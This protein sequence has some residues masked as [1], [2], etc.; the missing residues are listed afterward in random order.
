MIKAG[1][2]LSVESGGFTAGMAAAARSVDTFSQ[3]MEKAKSEKDFHK[4]ANLDIAQSQL[5]AS[6]LLFNNDTKSLLNDPRLK[7]VMANGAS[8]IK[9]D[10][11]K[12]SLFKDLTRSIRELSGKIEEQIAADD[13]AGAMETTSQLKAKQAEFGRAV[14]D[15]TSPAGK[16]NGQAGAAGF[17]GAQQIST[18][19]NEGFR[20]WADSFDRAGIVG[21]FGSGDVFGAH[22]SERRKDD[23]LIGG[24]V[25][26]LGNMIGGAMM[27]N[28]KTML[29]GL[30]IM[31]G[32]NIFN[33]VRQKNTNEKSTQLAY[34]GLWQQR[35]AE[36][37]ELAALKGT[38]GDPRG[39]F[40]AAAGAANRFGF[41]AEEGAGLLGQAL[42]EGLGGGLAQAVTEQVF[43][44][45]R[46]TGADR[47]ALAGIATMSARFG[48]GDALGAGWAGLNASG[49]ESGQYSEFL[50]GMQRV[51]EDGISR[52]FV[53]SSEEVAK[54]LTMLAAMSGNSPLWQGEHGARRLSDMNAGLAN[55]TGLG[56]TSDIVA[57]R[58]AKYLAGEGASYLDAMEILEGGVTGD[59]LNKFMRLTREIEGGDEAAIVERLRQTFGFNY[60]QARQFNSG[61]NSGIS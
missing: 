55:A 45:Q 32:A 19:I 50:R 20:I 34:A 35:A 41:S 29:A 21:Q 9:V 43:K 26:T 49:M 7:T 15:L 17:L 46:A 10:A 36:M 11:E 24:G 14:Q 51:M 25:S 59:F 40:S 33:A 54:N 52:G 3:A 31:L 58:A 22:L 27:F 28:P 37:M 2:E 13:I 53:R 56:S 38:P 30:G 60:T 61:W 42:R 23:A 1:I 12:A 48:A 57:F 39:A 44:H 47:G 5:K 8:G 4:A 18:A 6:S 16:K